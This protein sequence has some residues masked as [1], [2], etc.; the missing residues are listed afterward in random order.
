MTK[1]HNLIRLFILN[2]TSLLAMDQTACSYLSDYTQKIGII[3]PDWISEHDKAI[4]DS[5]KEEIIQTKNLSPCIEIHMERSEVTF[6]VIEQEEEEIYS[7]NNHYNQESS[8]SNQKSQNLEFSSVRNIHEA[9]FPVNNNFCQL[10]DRVDV[11][12]PIRLGGSEAIIKSACK[13]FSIP[14]ILTAQHGQ[15]RNRWFSNSNKQVHLGEDR[16]KTSVLIEKHLKNSMTLNFEPYFGSAIFDYILQNN[17]QEFTFI[18]EKSETRHINLHDLLLF[19]ILNEI[20]IVVLNFD[21]EN[22]NEEYHD[23]GKYASKIA[24]SGTENFLID[25]TTRKSTV[26][27]F[28]KLRKIGMVRAGFNYL[29]LCPDIAFGSSFGLNKQV[30]DIEYAYDDLNFA[31]TYSP[32]GANITAVEIHQRGENNVDRKSRIELSILKDSVRVLFQAFED[33]VKEEEERLNNILLERRNLEYTPDNERYWA[34]DD[35]I[36][37]IGEIDIGLLNS[38]TASDSRTNSINENIRKNCLSSDP[39]ETNHKS[40]NLLKKMR[41]QSFNGYSGKI[42]FNKFGYRTDFSISFLQAFTH[43]NVTGTIEN[44]GWKEIYRRKVKDANFIPMRTRVQDKTQGSEPDGPW[45]SKTQVK[46]TNGNQTFGA[47]GT[48]NNEMSINVNGVGPKMMESVLHHRIL[49]QVIR[50]TTIGEAPHIFYDKETK[51]FTGYCKDLMDKIQ[52]L[53]QDDIRKPMD[54]RE[55]HFNELPIFNVTLVKDGGYGK[56]M[57]CPGEKSYDDGELRKLCWDGMVG[58]LLDNVADVAIAPL[59]ITSFREKVVDFTTPFMN[60]GISIMIKKPGKPANTIFAFLD[61]LD[62]NIWICIL[63]AFISV[64]IVLFMISRLSPYEWHIV[65]FMKNVPSAEDYDVLDEQTMDFGIVNSFWFALGAIMQQGSELNPKSISGKILG[66]AWWLFS[67]IMV[68][69]YTANLAAF[70]TVERMETPIS[71]AAELANSPDVSYGIL[72]GGSTQEY[73]EQASKTDSVLNLMK[74]HIEEDPGTGPKRLVNTTDEGI[75]LVKESNGEYAF[76]LESSRNEYTAGQKDC[77]TMR[78]GRNLDSKGYGIALPKHSPIFDDFNLAV[79]KLS[80]TGVLRKMQNEWWIERSVCPKEASGSKTSELNLSTVAGLFYI[81]LT[82]MLMSIFV[83]MM[84]YQIFERRRIREK[85]RRDNKPGG[86]RRFSKRSLRGYGRAMVK[87]QRL[88][89]DL[90]V[91]II[92]NIPFPSAGSSRD[93]VTKEFRGTAADYRRLRVALLVTIFHV[94][95]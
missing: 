95:I 92:D 82:G 64:S 6:P 74:T 30:E 29:I 27:I 8:V 77:D 66:C 85:R 57:A 20:K 78:V 16:S 3:L 94:E 28:R 10:K 46:K 41:N 15:K 86:N 36:A 51:E 5:I 75:R 19:G 37:V 35:S 89:K 65:S 69:S 17:W 79:L 55:F 91:Q 68:S 42:K 47:P 59:T 67:L 50:V 7:T 11:I 53:F 83:A 48:H 21:T 22:Y 24:C 18:H 32:G 43:F 70:L 14:C 2:L 44:A 88:E 33:I 54:D 38:S 87:K 39:S 62:E 76:L 52:Q 56:S 9:Y 23:F 25:M 73:F 58:E 90:M 60:I 1:F 84:E 34:N 71:S 31:K 93:S 13:H 12:L 80:E 40:I 61:P 63:L 81:L 26:T 72:N 45:R 49:H 4:I